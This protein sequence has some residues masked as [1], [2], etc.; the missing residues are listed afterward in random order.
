MTFVQVWHLGSSG[1]G[2][3]LFSAVEDDVQVRSGWNGAF[4]ES[5][6]WEP[7]FEDWQL[8]GAAGIVGGLEEVLVG[9]GDFDESWE[10]SGWVG[11]EEMFAEWSIAVGQDDALIGIVLLL[12]EIFESLFFYV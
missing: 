8:V 10:G 2:F 12:N 1:F 3:T 5:R 11:D 7:A 9:V 6:E 4:W